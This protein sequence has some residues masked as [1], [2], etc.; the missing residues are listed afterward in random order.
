MKVKDQR[1]G[2]VENKETKRQKNKVTRENQCI[3]VNDLT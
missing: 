2:K 1:A 3:L